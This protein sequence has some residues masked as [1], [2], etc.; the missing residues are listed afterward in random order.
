MRD[1]WYSLRCRIT[2]AKLLDVPPDDLDVEP[3]LEMVE[4]AQFVGEPGSRGA[5]L[6]PENEKQEDAVIN[7]YY[8]IVMERIFENQLPFV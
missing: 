5:N 3:V 4:E 6:M 7:R 1:K 8:H 2:L